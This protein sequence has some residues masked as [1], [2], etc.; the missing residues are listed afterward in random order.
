M[1][2]A[3]AFSQS[4]GCRVYHLLDKP[5][6]CHFHLIER[7]NLKLCGFGDKVC[8]EFQ[9][10]VRVLPQQ[11]QKSLWRIERRTVLSHCGKRATIGGQ[12]ASTVGCRWSRVSGAQCS[13]M[14]AVR[15]RCPQPSA[16]VFYA[17]PKKPLKQL[18]LS[19]NAQK[20]VPS[21]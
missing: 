6:S 9:K 8:C 5:N 4:K 18:G 1:S 21:R 20:K 16:Y 13:K 2:I 10:D 11:L 7:Y 12:A 15:T 19:C 3:S 14:V 17:R